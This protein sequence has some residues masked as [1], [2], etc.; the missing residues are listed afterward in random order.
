MKKP[1]KHYVPT[2]ELEYWWE[3]WLQTGTDTA[4]EELSNRIYKICG[5]IAT[6]FHP[7]T[8][9]EK[10]EHIHDAWTQTMDKIRTRKLLFTKGKAPVFNLITTTV[11]RILYSKMN[12]QK[13]QRE[14][15]KKYTN[16]FIQANMPNII[17]AN[18]HYAVKKEDA[19]SLA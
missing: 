7:K 4:W 12:K 1:G 17:S 18:E 5:G 14:H 15:H 13:K 2:A 10:Q 9:E 11:F 19:E 6:H 16:L 8:E 3:Q